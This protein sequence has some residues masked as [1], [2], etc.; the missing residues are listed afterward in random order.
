ML[1]THTHLVL[2]LET[3]THLVLTLETPIP[4]SLEKGGG[5]CGGGGWRWVADRLSSSL[6]FEALIFHVA[7]KAG[8]SDDLW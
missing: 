8:W 7:R 4:Q 2:T 5:V 3:H 1:E 6:R